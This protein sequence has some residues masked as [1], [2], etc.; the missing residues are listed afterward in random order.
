MK[1]CLTQRFA[2]AAFTSVVILATLSAG[3][4]QTHHQ[5]SGKHDREHMRSD[6]LVQGGQGAFSAL[7]EAVARLES[8]PTTDWQN[9]NVNAL[10]DHLVD[11]NLLILESKAE[12]TRIDGG[13]RIVISATGRAVV[14]IQRM[15][16]AHAGQLAKTRGWQTRTELSA[17][18]ARWSITARTPADVSKI[19]ALGF[20]GL[21]TLEQHHQA[22][23]WAIIRGANPHHH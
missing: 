10:R 15:V 12:S 16:P 18:G 17:D 20:F 1:A 21:M 9:V 14:A 23:H 6:D 19:R 2:V 13:L 5:H 3:Q 11:M 22:H 7:A 8:D 4:A